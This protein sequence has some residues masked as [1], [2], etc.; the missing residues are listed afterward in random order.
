MTRTLLIVGT[1]DYTNKLG[2]AFSHA[3]EHDNL[4]IGIWPNAEIDPSDVHYILA[5]HYEFGLLAKFSHLKFIVSAGA[6]VDHLMSDPKLPDVPI[7]R[8]VDRHLTARM[9]TYVTSQVLFHTRRMSELLHAQ[10]K[11]KWARVI[12]PLPE[13]VRV[14]IMGL[15]ELGADAAS[16]LVHLGFQVR[17]WSRSEK[18]LPSVTSFHGDGQLGDFL[19]ETDI[20]VALLPLTSETKE[21]LNSSLFEQLSKHGRSEH[22]PGP[23][24]INPGRGGL[25]NEA[26]LLNAI[27]SGQL[28]AAS[29]DVFSEEPLSEA[30]PLWLEKHI[31]ITPHCA[32]VT[33][34]E[35]VAQYVLDN[36]KRHDA[37]LPLDNLVNTKREY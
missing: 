8:F 33:S 32:S 6:G 23:V 10:R 19:N 15:G 28:Y 35:R 17:G 36:I 9:T 4:K 29:L 1:D 7:V 12:D 3:K 24:L 30:S 27:R 16:A 21:I 11:R 13:E 34:P 20:L 31:V 2:P 18:H 5:W 37:D 26:D 22:L 25:Q 14:G